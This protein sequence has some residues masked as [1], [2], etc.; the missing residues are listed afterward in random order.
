MAEMPRDL[1]ALPVSFG[2]R[3]LLGLLWSFG[4]SDLFV[5][6][7]RRKLAEML[8][9]DPRSLR[10][11]LRKLEEVGAI[12]ESRERRGRYVREGWWLV[13]VPAGLGGEGDGEEVGA[14]EELGDEGQGE[15]VSDDVLEWVEPIEDDV[16]EDASDVGGVG[17]LDGVDERARGEVA[18]N[19]DRTVRRSGPVGPGGKG[20][21]RTGV[22]EEEDRT[23]RRGGPRSPSRRTVRSPRRNQEPPGT[24]QEPCVRD[25]AGRG[26]LGP[27]HGDG[28]DEPDVGD[29]LRALAR[30]RSDGGDPEGL[31]PWPEAVAPDGTALPR[32]ALR[33]KNL[34]AR[35][36]EGH[37]AV[38]V[39][40]AVHGFAALVG[41]GVLAVE[42]W[43][44]PY[45]FAG[46]F[47]G[48]LVEVRR[49]E[50][51]REAERQ[52]EL[53]RAEAQQ[54]HVD[55]LHARDVGLTVEEMTAAY[56]NSES[57]Q[58]MATVTRSIACDLGKRIIAPMRV[59]DPSPQDR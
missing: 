7:S 33:R 59:R 52:R 2:A 11:M 38:E 56:A 16:G 57:L 44:A 48:L 14:E 4:G 8:G 41:A 54:G 49:L 26:Q 13:E 6:P 5:W 1:Y 40:R 34:R 46:F 12:E 35:L 29:E 18:E 36:S 22:S 45:C 9:V 3:S 55:D 32:L 43:R 51:K 50:A 17:D 23:V 27:P 19:E 39:H 53:R 37:S 20:V 58:S 42:N 25:R 15:A 28:E 30:W 31:G 10:R 24:N 47:D 21:Q